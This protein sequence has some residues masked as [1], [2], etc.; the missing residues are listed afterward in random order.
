MW[1]ARPCSM[2]LGRAAAHNVLGCWSLENCKDFRGTGEQLATGCWSCADLPASLPVFLSLA[3]SLCIYIIYI[4]CIYMTPG[5][6]K[7]YGFQKEKIRL[8]KI[9]NILGPGP[10]RAPAW[11]G[12][13]PSLA[14]ARARLGPG[15]GSGSGP[16][17]AQAQAWARAR[18]GPRP[19]PGLGLGQG[20]AWARAWLGPGLGLGPDPNA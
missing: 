5:I 2:L 15:P 11:P 12:S 3:L 1:A 19:R 20:L 13:G 6:I 10:A 4:Y 17:W 18:P 8:R 7:V 16:A 9:T 14:R